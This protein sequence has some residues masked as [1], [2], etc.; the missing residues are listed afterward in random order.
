MKGNLDLLATVKEIKDRM[1]S[2]VPKVTRVRQ[3][4]VVV[5]VPTVHRVQ[6]V[7]VVKLVQ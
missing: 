5:T 6:E 1:E 4:H 3:V 2:Q 7:H